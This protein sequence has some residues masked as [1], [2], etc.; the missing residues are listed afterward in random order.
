MEARL[1]KKLFDKKVRTKSSIRKTIF[2]GKCVFYQGQKSH[3]RKKFSF[4][5]SR[6]YV[7]YVMFYH[8][9]DKLWNSAMFARFRNFRKCQ[10]RESNPCHCGANSIELTTMICNFAILINCSNTIPNSGPLF[11]WWW[12]KITGLFHLIRYSFVWSDTLKRDLEKGPGTT[13]LFRLFNINLLILF[14]HR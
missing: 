12:E 13:S 11:N 1:V 7:I 2:G 9:T 6:Q 14:L 10:L 5:I 4:N 8:Y 3:L